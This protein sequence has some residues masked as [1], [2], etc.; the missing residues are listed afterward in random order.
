MPIG[1]ITNGIHVRTWMSADMHSLLLQQLGPRW[2]DRIFDADL[3]TGIDQVRDAELWEVHQV[4][5]ARLLAFARRRLADRRERLGSAP[6]SASR[7]PRRRSPSASPAASP[8]TSAPT[9]CCATST[10]STG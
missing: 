5:K 9:C 2:L 8:P 6:R 1:H 3:W 10:A 7:S 4:L